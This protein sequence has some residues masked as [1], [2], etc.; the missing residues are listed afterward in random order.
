MPVILITGRAD[1]ADTAAGF[2][3]GVTDY[4]TK[5]FKPTHLV[6]RLQS[7]LI[8]FSFFFFA[9]LKSRRLLKKVQMRGGARG[10]HARRT[11]VR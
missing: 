1:A 4:L 9:L 10:P 3:A 11:A 2:N 6:A 5:P 7:W 8:R